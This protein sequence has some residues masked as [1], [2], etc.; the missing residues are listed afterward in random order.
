MS[1]TNIIKW[2]HKKQKV[3]IIFLCTPFQLNLLKECDIIFV[4]GTFRCCPKHF[5]QI[6]NLIG[7]LKDK[8]ITMSIITI[9]IKSK[10]ENSY[11]NLFENFKL[12][13]GK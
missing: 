9:M 3:L 7:H 13:L 5:Y 11:N 4:D 10:L 6:L 8:N 12:L 2:F 1:K